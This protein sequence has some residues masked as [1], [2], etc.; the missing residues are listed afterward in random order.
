M[1]EKLVKHALRLLRGEPDYIEDARKSPRNNVIASVMAMTTKQPVW[2]TTEA[3]A[4]AVR[5]IDE[6]NAK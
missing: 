5:R 3:V 4:E 1:D 6:D 2:A